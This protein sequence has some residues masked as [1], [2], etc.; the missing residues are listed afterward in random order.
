MYKSLVWS[1]KN[2]SQEH[3]DVCKKYPVQCPAACGVEVP[4]EKVCNF[5]C[6]PL[7]PIYLVSMQ[8]SHRK[9][10]V[11]PRLYFSNLWILKS[12][13][14]PPKRTSI[15]SCLDIP[16]PPCITPR[17]VW[18]SVIFSQILWEIKTGIFTWYYVLQ[19]NQIFNFTLLVIIIIHFLY[20]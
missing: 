11:E 9:D 5:V 10:K 7:T 15:I 2:L 12:C 4:R 20:F 16:L 6:S 13:L 1:P 18:K 3:I 17:K 14:R 19:I 8:E